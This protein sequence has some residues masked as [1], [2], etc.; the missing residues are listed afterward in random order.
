MP[1]V[2][3]VLATSQ[4]Q[5]IPEPPLI[6]YGSVV[7]NSSPSSVLVTNGVLRLTIT[8]ATEALVYS[9]SLAAV[10]DSHSYLL[11][12]PAETRVPGFQD[13]TNYLRLLSP[14]STYGI[15]S[16][17]LGQ[18]QL[19]LQA[20]DQGTFVM[21]GDARGAIRPVNLLF[22]PPPSG[23]ILPDDWQIKY[24]GR[25]GVDPNG[26][27]DR[28]G[29]SN[30]DEY[31]AGTD[32]MDRTFV[33][34]QIISLD[35]RKIRVR[36]NSKPNSQYVLEEVSKLSP[37]HAFAAPAATTQGASSKTNDTMVFD[38]QIDSAGPQR[39]FRIKN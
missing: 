39:F 10:D 2:H 7:D 5:G 27:P 37:D 13:S 25:L 14:P 1:V 32:P 6:F 31:K 3:C 35:P 17:V 8:N 9:T 11:A 23:N 24:F 34:I 20:P 28:D 30:L 38:I 4:A 26:D 21:N 29:I 18:Q 15:A 33:D 36:W 22:A 16:A 12:L 19:F